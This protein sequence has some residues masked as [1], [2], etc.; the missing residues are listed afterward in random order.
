MKL[1]FHMNRNADLLRAGNDCNRAGRKGLTFKRIAIGNGTAGR[2]R[3]KLLS[4]TWASKVLSYITWLIGLELLSY[5]AQRW[6]RE[7]FFQIW[8]WRKRSSIDRKGRLMIHWLVGQ[9]LT[10]KSYWSWS[11]RSTMWIRMPWKNA[12]DDTRHVLPWMGWE[13]NVN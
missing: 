13:W 12:L 9:E 5:S 8:I 6:Q 2:E 4:R 3:Q 10:Q 11:I 7:N 1:Y